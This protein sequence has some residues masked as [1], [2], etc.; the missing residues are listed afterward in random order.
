MTTSTRRHVMSGVGAIAMA[1]PKPNPDVIIIGAGLAGLFAALTLEAGGASVLVLESQ[2]R[3]GG[4]LRHEN[5]GGLSLDVGAIQIGGLSHRIR[6]MSVRMGLEVRPQSKGF[7]KIDF[8]INEALVKAAD[9][10]TSAVNKAVGDERS[11]R[12]ICWNPSSSRPDHRSNLSS[13]GV[14]PNI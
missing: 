6:A 8:H 3:P 7:G 1:R 4:R 11:I 13:S 9:W 14:T 5:G 10:E 2:D 12:P